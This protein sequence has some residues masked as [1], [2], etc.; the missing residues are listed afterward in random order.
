MISPLYPL[1]LDLSEYLTRSPPEMAKTS[2][3]NN[4]V[5]C[6]ETIAEQHSIQSLPALCST[7]LWAR[8]LFFGVVLLCGVLE[9][10][11]QSE[12]VLEGKVVTAEAEPVSNA[13]VSLLNSRYKAFTDSEGNFSIVNVPAG[14]YI[15]SVRKEG[16]AEVLREMEFGGR[17]ALKIV[18]HLESNKLG[19]VVITAQKREEL[20]Q[21]IPLSITSLSSQLVGEARIQTLEDLSAMAPNLYAAHPGDQ[22]S[23]V[24]IRGI[25]TTSYDPA[26]AVYLDG[27]SQFGLDIN[28]PQLFDIERIEVLRGPQGTLYGR[29]AMGGVINVITRQPERETSFFAEVTAG[30]Y[31]R[32]E[33]SA[34]MRVPL[35]ENKLYFG[36]AG[37]FR[38][39]DGFYTNEFTGGNYDEQQSFSGNYYLKYLISPSWNATLNYKQ[40]LIRN[41]GPFPLVMGIE[42]AGRNPFKL[43]QNQSTKLVDNSFNASLV[44]DHKGESINFSSQSS[45]QQNYHYYEEPIDADFSPLDAISIFN[46]YGRNWNKLQVATQE[47]RLSSAAGTDSKFLWTAGT[48]L[49]HSSNPV[50]QATRFGEDAGILGSEQTNFSVVNIGKATGTGA[51]FFGQ[52]TVELSDEFSI[53]GGLR[54]D[55]EYKEQ[56]VRGEYEPF[57]TNEPSFVFQQDTT[58]QA[59]FGALSPMLGLTYDLSD[60][61]LVFLTYRRGFR[62][63]GFTPLTSDASQPPLHPFD[64]EHSDNYEIGFKNMLFNQK[65]ILNSTLF[66]TEV[67]DVQVPTL[68]LPDA[69]TL[70]RNTGRLSSKGLELELRTILAKGLQ[71]QY[72]LGF[73]DAAYGSLELSEGGEVVN[74]GENRQIFTP[75]ITSLLSLQYERDLG[76]N[77]G[78]SIFLRG[79]WKY[80]GEHYFDLANNLK[81]DPY[82]LF[83]GQ[84]GVS[85]EDWRLIIWGRNLLDRRYISYGFDFG[86]VSLGNPLTFGTTLSYKIQ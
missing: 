45:F 36:A 17:I 8:L 23:V 33:I 65:L 70:T 38:K 12:T 60:D 44:I 35:V 75:D 4:K 54:Y 3:D 47:L 58:A 34:G 48:F 10:F 22:R 31:G 67:T 15:L 83:D 61:H 81:Q 49:F 13:V 62:T 51:A 55:Y 29:N 41:K 84:V 30:N 37:L 18:L 76:E 6:F 9:T 39:T 11:A 14:T 68:V 69:V 1:S 5:S 19:E 59:S 16:F 53:T 42:E 73:T 28:I 82:S 50:K 86:A 40:A 66:Y 43:N 74:Y 21:E 56:W 72:Q 52:G 57:S 85:Y 78:A 63:G 2:E 77:S 46:N 79:D 64:P 27:V 71:L 25:I 7:G 26:I 20:I 32:R 24:A 80:L